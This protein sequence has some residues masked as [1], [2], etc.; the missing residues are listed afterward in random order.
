MIARILVVLCIAVTAASAAACTKPLH[1]WI[2]EGQTLTSNLSTPPALTNDVHQ[3]LYPTVP[4]GNQNA[5]ITCGP[6]QS[7]AYVLSTPPAMHTGT[8]ATYTPFISSTFAVSPTGTF[9]YLNLPNKASP[10]VWNGFDNF[11]VV[12]KCL[13]SNNAVVSSCDGTVFVSVTFT[14]AASQNTA[15]AAFQAGFPNGVS[16]TGNCRNLADGLWMARQTLPRIWD[17][18]TNEAGNPVKPT[19]TASSITSDALEF[20]WSSNYAIVSTYGAIGNM[21]VRFPTF[22]PLNWAPGDAFTSTPGVAT[23]STG[24]DQTCLTYQGAGGQGTDLWAFNPAQNDGSVPSSNYLQDNTWY[25]KFNGK[26]SGCNAFTGSTSNVRNV[27]RYA[28]LLAPRTNVDEDDAGI[29]RLTVTGC[30]LKWQGKFTW[31]AMRNQVLNNG[32]KAFAINLSGNDYTITGEMYNQAVQPNSWTEPARGYAAIDHKYL[33]TVVLSQNTDFEFELGVDIFT[34]DLQQFR[35]FETN[36]D[37]SFGYNMIVY[38]AK[39][40]ALEPNQA[41]DRRVTGFTWFAQQWVAPT[42][43]QCPNCG[44]G[45][46]T[47]ECKPTVTATQYTGAMDAPSC[48]SPVVVLYKGPSTTAAQCSDSPQ[49]AVLGVPGVSRPSESSSAQIVCDNANYQNITLRGTA[50]GSNQVANLQTAGFGFDGKITLTFE[51]ANGEHPHFVITPKMYVKS[52]SVDGAF[53]GSTSTCRGSPSWPV[54]NDQQLPQYVCEEVD[55]RTFGPTD[56]AA[57]FFDIKDVDASLVSVQNLKIVIGTLEVTFENANGPSN[58]FTSNTYK[59]FNYR[60]LKT[61]AG[62]DL[63]NPTSPSTVT[64]PQNTDF[65]FAFTPGAHNENSKIT[66]Y[67]TLRIAQTKMNKSR[68]FV[69]AAAEDAHN[70]V[71]ES[72]NIHNANSQSVASQ[73]RVV[74][75][76]SS[77]SSANAASSSSSSSNVTVIVLAAACAVLLAAV[78]GMVLYVVRQ[79][80]SASNSVPKRVNSQA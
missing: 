25:Q 40:T 75:S 34:V 60:N 18:A 29:W 30:N 67:C 16:C 66:I 15:A 65:G 52:I 54:A 79:R 14:S 31:N 47:T 69:S 76:Q 4:V 51:L 20:E 74:E 72:I 3:T 78:I 8:A 55:A 42:Q 71:Q 9:T 17:V 58:Y 24:F 45:G 5:L 70:T 37:R 59:Y 57:I 77:T 35:Y 64:S 36:G 41:P 73:Q 38:P 23:Q 62:F 56:W 12:A 27:C 43:Q 48:A 39:L 28:P 13:D 11:Q 46:T 68:R 22:E 53:A 1:Y 19:L 7:L 21:A 50:P 33:L 80:N 32:N 10:V 6:G 2:E 49:L 61:F 44:T 63:S 26:H